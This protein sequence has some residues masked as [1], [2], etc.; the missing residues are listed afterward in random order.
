MNDVDTLTIK[1][2]ELEKTLKD[3]KRSDLI[4]AAKLRAQLERNERLEA[5]L[6]ASG[7]PTEVDNHE[8]LATLESKFQ[9][10]FDRQKRKNE[11]VLQQLSEVEALYLEAQ[12]EQ[13]ASSEAKTQL[14]QVETALDDAIEENQELMDELRDAHMEIKRLVSD[15]RKLST[16]LSGTEGVLKPRIAQVAS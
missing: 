6:A 11:L 2:Q 1:I 12:K 13:A 3:T 9:A 5:K 14:E 16:Q 8:E 10:Q 15:N 7:I 4:H